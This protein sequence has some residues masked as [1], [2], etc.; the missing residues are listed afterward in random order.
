MFVVLLGTPTVVDHTPLVA[1]VKVGAGLTA[2]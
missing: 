1:C 2:E